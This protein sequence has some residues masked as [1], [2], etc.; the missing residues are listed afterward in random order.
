MGGEGAHLQ[1]PYE[2][3][4]RAPATPHVPAALSFAIVRD[5]RRSIAYLVL[6]Y[7]KHNKCEKAKLDSSVHYCSLCWYVPMKWT[8]CFCEMNEIIL[9][10]NQSVQC[11]ISPW[12]YDPVLDF[13][14]CWKCSQVL[15]A[16]PTAQ[17]TLKMRLSG[18]PC[19]IPYSSL[20][21]AGRKQREWS[22]EASENLTINFGPVGQPLCCPVALWWQS[23]FGWLLCG[24]RMWKQT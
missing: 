20:H 16:L 8:A 11:Q 18:W 9:A 4:S 21:S 19:L 24:L 3:G 14:S 10:W 15:S 1:W 2:E 17:R 13:H 6:N 7:N 5:W 23:G 22:P 12:I